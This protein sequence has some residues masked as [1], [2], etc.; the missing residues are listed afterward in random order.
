[1][2]AERR[3]VVSR[4]ELLQRITAEYDEMP[5]MLLTVPQAQRLF[6]LREDICLRVL[7]A[8]VDSAVLRQDASGAYGRAQRAG[9]R[10][11]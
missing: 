11:P 2:T 10:Q 5:G 8:L 7:S 9:K 6:G 1:V 4:R 3:N